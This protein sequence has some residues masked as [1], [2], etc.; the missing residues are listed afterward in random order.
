MAAMA[1][2]L[3]ALV[4]CVSCEHLLSP[5]A[6]A[7]APGA[8]FLAL[9]QP[10]SRHTH[11]FE[12]LDSYDLPRLELEL[13]LPKEAAFVPAHPSGALCWVD[14]VDRETVRVASSRAILTHSTYS[15]RAHSPSLREALL[16]E[17]K[18]DVSGL[19]VLDVQRPSLSRDEVAAIRAEVADTLESLARLRHLHGDHASAP[20]EGAATTLLI[21]DQASAPPEGAATTLLIDQD[22]RFLVGRQLAQGLAGG[23]GLPGFRPRRRFAGV[24]GT[25]ALKQRPFRVATTMEVELAFLLA[26]VASV[27]PGSVVLDPCCGSGG[28][29]LCAAALG[30]R[31][32]VGRDVDSAALAGAASNFASYGLAQQ[33]DLAVADILQS[34]TAEDDHCG[35]YDAIV[36]DPPYG[37]KTALSD[38]A[39]Q[40][41]GSVVPTSIRP[42]EAR[43]QVARVTAAIL[44]LAL[45]KLRLGGRLAFFLPVRG[46]DDLAQDARALLEQCGIGDGLCLVAARKQAFSPTFARWLVVVE[47]VPVPQPRE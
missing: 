19:C 38:S 18:L 21:D 24:L 39:E 44:H 33:P 23:P 9:L 6:P 22:G 26:S 20:P 7:R 1:A 31:R 15:I 37:M 41:H 46:A 34:R 2:R 28:L 47:R 40:A 43:V 12:P 16:H 3:L 17:P 36:C 5:G 29:L 35:E 25:Y 32:L 27:Q 11:G 8:R 30:A 10:R 45:R 4:A 13:L 42:D 14:G